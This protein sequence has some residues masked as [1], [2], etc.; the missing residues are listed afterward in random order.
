MSSPIRHILLDIEGT[1][2]PVS[3]VSDVLFPYALAALP[4]YLGNHQDNPRLQE[5][6]QTLLDCWRAEQ[7]PEAVELRH[8][9]L[10]QSQSAGEP[11]MLLPFL[12]WLNRRDIK[13]TPWKELQGLIWREGYALGELKAT[14]FPEVAACLRRWHQQGQVLSVYSSGSVA[15]QQLLYGHSDDGDLTPLFSHWF[16][17]HIGLKEEAQSYRR[18]LKKLGSDGDAVL[19]ISD[20]LTELQAA[21]AAGIHCCLSDRSGYSESRDTASNATRS[22]P[23]KRDFSQS[24]FPVLSSLDQVEPMLKGSRS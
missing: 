1:T 22:D 17:T 16:D 20:S 5:L 18:I 3:F 13:L 2:C 8:R 23:A 15:A 10:S 7:D 11:A 24:N 12:Q 14:L 6:Q 19:F 9:A 4:D 21:S